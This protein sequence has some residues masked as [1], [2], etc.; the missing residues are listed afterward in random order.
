MSQKIKPITVFKDQPVHRVLDEK[1]VED[2][3]RLVQSVSFP[4]AKWYTLNERAANKGG[5]ISRDMGV[6]L[7][8]QTG[9]PVV[10]GGNFLHSIKSS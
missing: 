4:K 8:D 1:G 10:I 5:R 6:Q 2:I 7:E 3:L 9:Q